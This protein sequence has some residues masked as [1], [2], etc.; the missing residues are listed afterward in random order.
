MFQKL[1]RYQVQILLFFI[2]VVGF[3]VIRYYE[4]VFFYD[5]LLA[6]FKG[7]YFNRPLPLIIE[8]KLYFGFFW[9]YFL[10]SV[11]SIFVICVLFKN[12]EY[13][14]LA[15][16]LYLLFFVVLMVLFIFVLRYFSEQVMA[17][18][19][20]RRFII[21]PLFLLLFIPGFYFQQQD[22]KKQNT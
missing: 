2:S 20:I 13:V 6:F 1:R 15:T 17:L 16:F 21:Q 9:R 22:L 10:N 14:K 12:K 11:L 4:S 18:F 3:A 7:E 5:P 8:W 19:Y